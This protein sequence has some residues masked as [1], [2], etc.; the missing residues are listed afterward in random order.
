[1]KKILVALVLAFVF[2]FPLTVSAQEVGDKPLLY[3]R[4]G[5]SHCAKVDA[6]LIKYNLEDKVQKIETL[7]NE[8]NTK[9][10]NSW[11][12]KLNVTDT[13]QQGVPFLVI[14]DK[15]YLVGD[16]PIIEY[17]AKQDNITIEVDEY[18]SSTADT[19]FLAVG[20][21]LLFG[22]LGYGVYSSFKKKN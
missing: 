16:V 21:L 19:I 3:V 7:N 8:E 1:M 11:F 4:K 5:C 2:L 20:G 14:D 10:L 18:Q 13:N 6:F 12:T 22:V 17:L 15:T 9:Q